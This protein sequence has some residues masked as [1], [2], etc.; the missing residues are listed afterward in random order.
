[1]TAIV[2]L[3]GEPF[4]DGQIWKQFSFWQAGWSPGRWR[5]P[6]FLIWLMGWGLA[7]SA[8]R[9]LVELLASLDWPVWLGI[10]LV[11]AVGIGWRLKHSKGATQNAELSKR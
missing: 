5:K 9:G 1:V 2:I 4:S 10:F 6:P 11:L 3:G 7:F 8:L